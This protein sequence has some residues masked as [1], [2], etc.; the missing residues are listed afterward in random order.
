[1]QVLGRFYKRGQRI[2]RQRAKVNDNFVYEETPADRASTA[3]KVQ[4][5]E[6][7]R[8]QEWA[9]CEWSTLTLGLITSISSIKE[10]NTKFS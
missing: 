4:L 5:H 2:H 1:M 6:P 10:L 3:A 8:I 7:R 9:S